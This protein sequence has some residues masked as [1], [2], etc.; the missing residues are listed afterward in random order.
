LHALFS[1]QG[2]SLSYPSFEKHESDNQTF[3][4][5]SAD[6][7][8]IYTVDAS[9]NTSKANMLFYS[10]LSENNGMKNSSNEINLADNSDDIEK[11]ISSSGQDM[12]FIPISSQECSQDNSEYDKELTKCF[13][14]LKNNITVADESSEYT[15]YCISS[16]SF[17]HAVKVMKT[18]PEP[19]MKKS[20][21][22]LN[23]E[24]KFA[25]QISHPSIR[26]PLMKGHYLNNPSLLLEWVDGT[27]IQKCDKFSVKD[28]LTTSASI[29]HALVAIHDRKV[30]HG[31]LT[32][33]H[34]IVNF[35]SASATIISF[36]LS[37]NFNDKCH[38]LE[39]DFQYTSPEKI[40]S[41]NQIIDFR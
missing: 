38:Q 40:S 4:I 41:L 10:L 9:S 26:K 21:E 27:P 2:D 35:N 36:G 15:T 34:I 5:H 31:N 11:P 18:Q 19:S 17:Q 29:L 23:N 6:L 8:G 33:K 7:S 39:G 28:F 25:N 13:D 22:K 32:A 3:S 14:D 24:H 12:S 37:S 16:P 20:I 1:C 30:I